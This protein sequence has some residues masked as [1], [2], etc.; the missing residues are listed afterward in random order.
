MILS[1]FCMANI[2]SYTFVYMKNVSCTI[3]LPMVHTFFTI[4]Q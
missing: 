3:A 4:E 2:M 1:R